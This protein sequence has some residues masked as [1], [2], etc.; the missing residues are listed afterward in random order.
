M[1]DVCKISRL[2]DDPG[3][4]GPGTYQINES[5]VRHSPKS[6]MNWQ[7]SKSMR[8]GVDLNT[9][10]MNMNVGPGSY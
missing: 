4:V 5:H 6:T 7:T 3:K 9:V 2:V 8:S 1:Q 10:M